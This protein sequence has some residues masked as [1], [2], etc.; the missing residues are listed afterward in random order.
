[1]PICYDIAIDM[2]YSEDEVD[3]RPSVRYGRLTF[4]QPVSNEV[5]REHVEQFWQQFVAVMNDTFPSHR[6]YRREDDN[7]RV[8]SVIDC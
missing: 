4:P 1:M 8:I 6:R 5:L 2:I 7:F 3:I